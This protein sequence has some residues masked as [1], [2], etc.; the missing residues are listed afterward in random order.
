MP[1]PQPPAQPIPE[2]PAPARTA[3]PAPDSSEPDPTEPAAARAAAAAAPPVHAFRPGG[4]WLLGV[5]LAVLTFWLFAQS[6]LNVIPTIRESLGMSAAVGDLAVSLTALFAGIFVVVAGGIGD[7]I[8]Q[9]VVF[10]VGIAL[11]ILGAL[12]LVLTPAHQGA[13]TAAL[14]LG[15]RAVLGLST[16]C[17]MPSAL[18]L[19]STFFEGPER[20][21]AVSMFSLGTFGGLGVASLAGGLIAGA[22]GW[23]TIFLISIAASLLAYWWTRRTP[24]IRPEPSTAA[25]RR[26][27]WAGLAVFFVALVGLNVYISQGRTLGWTSAAGLG[28]LALTALAFAAFVALSLRRGADAFIDLRMFSNLRFTGPVVANFLMNSTAAIIIVSLGLMQAAAGWSPLQAGLLTIGHLVCVI[29]AIRIG[30]KLLQ[31]LGPKR[32]MLWGT[33]SGMVGLLLAACTFLPLPAYAP[34]TALG[35][36]LFGLGQGLFATPAIDATITSVPRDGVGAASGILKMGSTL[37]QAIG[38]SAATAL[39]ALGRESAPASIAGWAATGWLEGTDPE[40]FGAM[41]GAGLLGVIAVAMVLSVLVLVPRSG[42][43]KA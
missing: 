10:R 5:V 6:L 23:R 39:S 18:S 11:S 9:T 25:R 35:L 37:G 21:R 3:P 22:L 30:E 42:A 41:L 7:R 34:V 32:P 36:A 29:A 13:L 43:P 12:L 19:I 16:A 2:D 38:V 15:G 28:L 27:D 40:R 8:G 1:D 14:F 26:F 20:Q 17:I 31:R 4:T 33:L 24:W